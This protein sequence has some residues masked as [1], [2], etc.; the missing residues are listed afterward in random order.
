MGLTWGVLWSAIGALVA[1]L[2]GAMPA[3]F[4]IQLEIVVG[5]AAQFAALG[6]IG[7]AAFSV[8]LWV[9]EGRRSFDQMSLPRFAVWGAFGGLIMWAAR[10]TIG[11]SVMDFLGSVGVPGLNWG[12]AVSGGIIVLLGAG[13]AAGSLALARSVD[14]PD[15]LEAGEG[16][17]EVGLTD[18]EARKLL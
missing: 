16:V 2:P 12:Y 4:P 8:V 10:G 7:G 11:W 13:S 17:A 9:T 5:F 6:F 15:L 1:V 3:G 18:E 14:D